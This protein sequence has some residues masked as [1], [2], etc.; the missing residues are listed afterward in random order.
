MYHSATYHCRWSDRHAI[1]TPARLTKRQVV[2]PH[3]TLTIIVPEGTPAS[4]C[5]AIQAQYGRGEGDWKADAYSVQPAKNAAE[6][7]DAKRRMALLYDVVYRPI[8]EMAMARMKLADM[9]KAQLFC[10][11]QNEAHVARQAANRER[12]LHWLWRGKPPPDALP[13]PRRRP[14]R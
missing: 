12:F 11:E 7:E 2:C 1:Q 9:L 13:P 10:L 8:V 3:F 6:W 5:Q 4:E 14:R